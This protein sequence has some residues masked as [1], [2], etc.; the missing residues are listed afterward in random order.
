M[1]IYDKT[2]GSNRRF[3]FPLALKSKLNY[4]DEDIEI[5]IS[6]LNPLEKTFLK[7]KISE[8]KFINKQDKNNKIYKIVCILIDVSEKK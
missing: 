4:T 6:V 5:C 2:Y 8:L 7:R 1:T 3:L